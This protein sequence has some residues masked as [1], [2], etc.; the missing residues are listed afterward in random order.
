MKHR[1]LSTHIR[2]GAPDR[3]NGQTNKQTEVCLCPF[4]S[5]TEF[6]TQDRV[7]P[8]DNSNTKNTNNN[9]NQLIYKAP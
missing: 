8:F 6:D 1:A 5:Q 9:N 2:T 4:V 7:K 3:Q